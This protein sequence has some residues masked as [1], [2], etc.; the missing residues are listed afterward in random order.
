VA[1]PP[2]ASPVPANAVVA[3]S[4]G[5]S[6]P[7]RPAA[8]TPSPSPTTDLPALIVSVQPFLTRTPGTSATPTPL[9]APPATS[10]PRPTSTRPSGSLPDP[11]LTRSTRIPPP[12]RTPAPRGTFTGQRPGPIPPEPRP[13]GT[14]PPDVNEPNDTIDR[15]TPLDASPIEA[16][17]G[18]PD[19][20]DVY[21]VDVST[22]EML[23]VVTLT[24][25]QANRYKVDVVAPR[26]GVV[27]R[28]RL[29]GTVALRAIAEV[30]SNTGTYYVFVQGVGRELPKGPYFISADVV[31][32]A[33]TPTSTP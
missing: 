20:V 1:G 28:Q 27:G 10:S 13:E 22:P 17:I 33:V 4:E 30:G 19:D 2:T 3:I 11:P 32:P 24:G 16:A 5:G 18:G 6:L 7:T 8:G 9:L 14:P 23:L 26:G 25:A 29:D 15:A 21:R 12:T 31:S